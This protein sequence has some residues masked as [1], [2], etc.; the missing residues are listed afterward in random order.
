MRSRP[1]CDLGEVGVSG[2]RPGPDPQA[3]WAVPGPLAVFAA[4][5]RSKEVAGEWQARSAS[6]DS[7]RPSH[8]FS[9]LKT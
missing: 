7:A 9:W 5:L 1:R 8:L 2:S 3:S 4:R 6:R